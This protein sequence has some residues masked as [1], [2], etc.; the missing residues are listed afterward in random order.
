MA[1]LKLTERTAAT[2]RAAAG[3]R[4]EVWD[5]QTPGLCLRVSDRRK[6]WI[7]RYRTLDG[8]QPRLTIGDYSDR[9]GLKWAREQVEE[10]RVNVRKGD[11]PAGAKKLARAQAQNEPLK[12]FTDLTAAYFTA[13]EKGHYR[14]RRKQK[15][16]STIKGERGIVRR[17]IEAVLGDLRLEEIGRREIRKLLNDMM[18]R[19]IGAQTNQTHA[20][21]RQIFAYGI[22]TERVETNPAAS[23]EKPAVGTPRTRVLTD[24]E[25]VTFWTAL[26]TLPADLRLPAKPGRESGA[27]VYVGR[28]MRIAL[29]LATLLLVRR[30]EIAGM[31]RS[32]LNLQEKTWL[33]PGERMKSGAPHLVP[34][35]PKAV[36][37]IEEAMTLS[38]PAEG[39]T[40]DPVFPSP[41]DAAKAVRCDSVTHAMVG[42][43]AALRMKP[44]SPHDLRRTGSTALTSERCGVAPYIRSKVLGHRDAGG[45]AMVSAVHYD[46]N[47]YIAEKRR[48]LQTWENLLLEIVGERQRVSN[49]TLISSATGDAAA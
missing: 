38:E 2:A 26:N 29:Q 33:I 34:L 36:A 6:V 22:H 28:G 49:V 14:P 40:P 30:S 17:Y 32:E 41:R 16:A 35:P 18:D 48:A 15:R 13:C 44:A 23:I 24:K 9:H 37:L 10:L 25:L 42:I 8:R 45:G 5:E 19:G 12:R 11:D 39:D 3:E 20:V 4:V 31:R 27:R 1:K 47:D 7:Y 43:L 21:I 46:T